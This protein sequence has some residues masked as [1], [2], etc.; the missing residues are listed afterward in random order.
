MKRIALPIALMAILLV[1]CNVSTAKDYGPTVKMKR[2]AMPFCEVEQDGVANIIFQQGNEYSVVVEGP[3][4]LVNRIEIEFSDSVLSIDTED[5]SNNRRNNNNKINVYLISPDLTRVELDGVGSFR[6]KG[7]IDT[8]QLRIS[9]DGVGLVDIGPLICDYLYVENDGV[10]KVK[11]FNVTTQKAII[12]MDGVGK[13][14]AHFTA[15]DVAELNLEGT[16]KIDVS[17]KI[18]HVYKHRNGLGSISVSQEK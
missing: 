6:T 11:L 7:N 17:G 16:G 2:A 15:C 9:N 14:T 5:I 12:N 10:G 4:K 3:E 13:A 8:D 1:A 18:R